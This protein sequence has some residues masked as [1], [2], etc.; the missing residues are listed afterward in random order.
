MPVYQGTDTTSA[1]LLS[2][3]ESKVN[4]YK[5]IDTLLASAEG[6]REKALQTWK[7]T[8]E[9]AQ[10]VKIREQLAKLEEAFTKLAEKNVPSG[11]IPEEDKA[12]LKAELEALKPAIR[13]AFKSI[14]E[15]SKTIGSDPEGVAK[16]LEE[17]GDPTKSGRGRK[18]G[19][20]GSGLPRVSVNVVLSGGGMD[21]THNL[22]TFSE[23]A[24]LT[25]VDVADVQKAFAD[26]AGVDPMDIKSAFEKA[27]TD[28]I[29]FDF[30][31]SDGKRT[32]HVVATPKERAP[33]GSKKAVVEA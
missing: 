29:E 23:V 14:G 11:D 28:S 18:P 12:K 20:A 24:K 5:E 6:D 33:R 8:S 1:A 26:A 15:L 19:V 17:I 16:A 22:G 3:Y 30:E 7:E 13:V 2:S 21:K 32:Y 9:D 31:S 25:L 27:G 4:K 10:A